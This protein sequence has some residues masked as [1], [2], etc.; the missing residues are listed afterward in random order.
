MIEQKELDRISKALQQSWSL[1]SSGIW[2]QEFPAR[3]QCGVTAIVV[4]DTFGGEILKTQVDGKPHFY[5]RLGGHPID[6]TASQFTSSIEY[7]HLASSREEAFTDTS[8][9]QVESLSKAFKRAYNLETEQ[10]G[11]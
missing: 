3:G 6:F 11:D 1:E 4:Y 10:Q 8:Q 9:L 7:Q 5:N 2:C